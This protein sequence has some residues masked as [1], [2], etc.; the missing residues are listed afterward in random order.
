M[1]KILRE[2]LHYTNTKNNEFLKIIAQFL[3]ENVDL[4]LKDINGSTAL[5]LAF[6]KNCHHIIRMIT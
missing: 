5:E 6:A 2:R 3:E 4:N 1:H